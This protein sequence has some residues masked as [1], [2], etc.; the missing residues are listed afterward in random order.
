[1]LNR[2]MNGMA[3]PAIVAVMINRVPARPK[4]LL[5]SNVIRDT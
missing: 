4:F 1:M 5:D 3:N 2:L